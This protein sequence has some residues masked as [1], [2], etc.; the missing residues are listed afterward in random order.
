MQSV[1]VYI[2]CEI[3]YFRFT[4]KNIFFHGVAIKLPVAYPG[5]SKGVLICWIS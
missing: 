4:A 5:L 2:M 1:H 3:Y